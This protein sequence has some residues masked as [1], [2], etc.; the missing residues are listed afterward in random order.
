MSLVLSLLVVFPVL[1]QEEEV[2]PPADRAADGA[3]L[4]ARV[5]GEEIALTELD[6]AVNQ[7]VMS[8][9]LGPHS[10][11]GIGEIQRTVLER[12]VTILVVSR[13]AEKAGFAATDQEVED[14]LA[15]IRAQLGSPEDYRLFLTV[16]NITE[17]MLRRQLFRQISADKLVR[18]QVLGKIE[19]QDTE[20]QAYYRSHKDELTAPEKVKLRH[21]FV[22]IRPDMTDE[23][24]AA[25]REKIDSAK[26]QLDAGK[27]FAELAVAVSEDPAAA[28]GGSLG[29]MRRD[30]VTGPFEV[31]AFSQPLNDASDVVATDYGYHIIEVLNRKDPGVMELEEARPTIVQQLKQDKERVAVQN[32]LSDLRSKAAVETFLP[33]EDVDG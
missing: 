24:R 15:E 19:I 32:Y 8:Q 14:A 18:T 25:A 23:E 5:D 27:E 26:A 3:L 28:S 33:E 29:W 6:L 12:L 31:V 22:R 10:S 11:V 7:Y 13:H 1:A 16:Q 2:A 17:E 20:I 21:I 30:Q 4:A 9:G